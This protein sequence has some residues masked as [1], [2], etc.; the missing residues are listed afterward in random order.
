MGNWAKPRAARAD[1]A[2]P[3]PDATAAA[4]LL[5]GIAEHAAILLD[6]LVVALLQCRIGQQLGISVNTVRNHVH[7]L[8]RKL[9][10]ANRTDAV[11]TGLRRGLVDLTG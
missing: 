11:A 8:M 9:Q 2:P 10:V 4:P 1:T 3:A 6:Q 7:S 5:F